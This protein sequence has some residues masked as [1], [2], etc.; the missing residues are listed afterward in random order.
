MVA[1]L[2]FI[3]LKNNL[4]G[5]EVSNEYGTGDNEIISWYQKYLSPAKGDH[6]PM[7]PSC[8]QYSKMVLHNENFILAYADVCDRLLRCGN[9]LESYDQ[10]EHS[11]HFYYNDSLTTVNSSSLAFA[12]SLIIENDYSSAIL[13]LK[14]LK[15][16]TK[17][18]VLINLI[19]FHIA[20]CYFQSKNYPEFN[21]YFSNLIGSDIDKIYKDSLVFLE[22]KVL[23]KNS[24]Y[25]NSVFLINTINVDSS[26]LHDDFLYLKGADYIYLK[27]FDKAR[28]SFSLIN[29]N[30]KDFQKAQ[31]FSS[32]DYFKKNLHLKSA[33]FAAYSS[34][35]IPGVGYIYANRPQTGIV[36]FII[37][38]LFAYTT[39]EAIHNK[40]YG[41]GAAAG[42]LGLG[43]YFGTIRGSWKSVID[44]NKNQ[45][46][47][48]L[49]Y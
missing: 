22:S 43:W 20:K 9:D 31:L 26:K 2:C 35:I 27:E 23:Q 28:Y 19:N 14:R 4:T 21:Q 46:N 41:L 15:Y 18:K 8:S 32:P 29:S 37:N 6:C 13:E 34:A 45:I 25:T 48:M 39:V 12:N 36:S 3:G 17:N 49:N 24:D 11:G 5:Q 7:Y 16:V 47:N 33:S 40:Q 38:A 44:Y 30:S 42:M 1:S 10:T